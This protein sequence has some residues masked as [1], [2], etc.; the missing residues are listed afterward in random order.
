MPISGWL[1]A[2]IFLNGMTEVAAQ[3]YPVKPIRFVVTA[4]AGGGVDLMARQIAQ[5]IAEGLG[6][7]VV[8]DNRGGASGVIGVEVVARSAPDG[9]TMMIAGN[10]FLIFPLLGEKVSYDPIRDFSPITLATVSPNI[11]VVH[12]SV[13]ASSVKD[14]IALARAQPGKLN[15]AT[16]SSG[17]SPHMAGEL[18]KAMAKVD[19]VRVPY[20]GSAPAIADLLGGQV[21]LMFSTAVSVVTHIKSGRLKALA[22]SSAQRS[23]VAPELPTIAESALPGYESGVTYGLLMRAGT[24]EAYVRMINRETAKYLQKTDSRTRLLAEGSEAVGGSPAEYSAAMKA[25]IRKWAKVIKDANIR[26]D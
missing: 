7:Q 10:N 21:Q 8:V 6:Q 16:G 25:E 15:Y 3:R 20:K 12:P 17:A 22:I 13:A 4:P 2:L 26:V 14:L 9:Y 24:P 1:V 23:Q 5:N 11:L 19:I 18:F